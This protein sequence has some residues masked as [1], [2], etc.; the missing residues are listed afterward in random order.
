[1][2]TSAGT[3]VSPHP[4]ASGTTAS[5]VSFLRGVNTAKDVCSAIPC[6]HVDWNDNIAHIGAVCE[7]IIPSWHQTVEIAPKNNIYL[8]IFDARTAWSGNYSTCEVWERFLF[9]PRIVLIETVSELLLFRCSTTEISIVLLWTQDVS[10]SVSRYRIQHR[11]L[12]R[13]WNVQWLGLYPDSLLLDNFRKDGNTRDLI[14]LPCLVRWTCR[15]NPYR[16]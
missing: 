15:S 9:V 1:M 7:G 2:I 16:H 5:P 10:G 13:H 11:Q 8:W 12:I 14:R 3:F 6:F 4:H